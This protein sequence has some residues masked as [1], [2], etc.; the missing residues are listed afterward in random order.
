VVVV[1]AWW[2]R[3]LWSNPANQWDFRVYYY[4]AQ[5]W[6]AGRD[7]YAASALPPVLGADTL[8]FLYPPYT[9][10][11]FALFAALPLGTALTVYLALKLALLAWLVAIWTRLLCADAEPSWVLF[12]VFAY[13]S[14]IFVDCASGNVT[15]FEQWLLWIGI[16][17][18]LAGRYWA[19]VAAVVGASLFKLTPILLLLV[20][21]MLPVRHRWRYVA[22]GVLAFA[23][24]L[25]ATYVTSPRLT[26]EF[27]QAVMAIDERGRVSPSSLALVRDATELAGRAL[28]VGVRAVVQNAIYAALVAVVVATTWLAA[29]R[30]AVADSPNRTES[31]VYLALLAY[32]LALPRFKIYGYMLAI[33]PT[34]FIAMRSTRL[35]RAVPLL[36]LA[37]LPVY[38]WITRPETL[39]LVATYSPWLIALGAWGLFVFELGGGP[40]NPAAAR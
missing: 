34:Y 2:L 7:P 32:V 36:I 4:A 33:P 6:T 9:L 23:A 28:G 24:L 19:Y 5:A 18:L 31:I 11:F 27:V 17:A 39:T 16:A 1:A 15:V 35:Q 14:A 10:G 3:K 38:S 22:G 13:S 21:A 29:R 30:I 25:L 37:C 26:T 8:P 40:P 12:L 20:F